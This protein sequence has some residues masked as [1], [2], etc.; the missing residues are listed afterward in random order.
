[1]PQVISSE[2]GAWII[3]IPRPGLSAGRLPRLALSFWWKGWS[4]IAPDLSREETR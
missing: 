1:M 2:A 3:R 4:S